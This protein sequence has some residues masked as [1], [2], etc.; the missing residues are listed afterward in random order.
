MD[1]ALGGT[2]APIVRRDAGRD[3][4]SLTEEGCPRYRDRTWCGDCARR[5][6]LIMIG[7]SIAV[8]TTAD[9]LLNDPKTQR[10]YSASAPSP[11]PEPR[12]GRMSGSEATRSFLESIGLPGGDLHDLLPGEATSPTCDYR[13]EDPDRRRPVVLDARCGRDR[14]SRRT[15]PPRLAGQRRVPPDDDELDRGWPARSEARSRSAS[16]RGRTPPGT[17]RR[18]HERRRC[19]CRPRITVPGADRSRNRGREAGRCSRHTHV[20]E[21]AISG[22]SPS[23]A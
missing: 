13:V 16:S 1:E 3:C 18:W 22:C 5:A 14:A 17:H 4:K 7:G 20:P 2:R 11:R 23:S 6:Q 8:E 10:R 21:S 15:R 12:A 9:K 19:G